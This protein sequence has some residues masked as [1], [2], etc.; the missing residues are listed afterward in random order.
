MSASY[1]KAEIE[2]KNPN[3]LPL[4]LRKLRLICTKTK[5]FM[6]TFWTSLQGI[7]L[8]ANQQKEKLHCHTAEL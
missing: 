6:W 7:S 3:K 4:V 5:A 8:K 2:G 1:W